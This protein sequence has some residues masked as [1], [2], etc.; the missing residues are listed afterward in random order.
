MG[1]G[2]GYVLRDMRK[3]D[4]GV[5]VT[6]KGNYR[7]KVDHVEGLLKDAGF[8]AT[9]K[10]VNPGEAKSVIEV[11]EF[12]FLPE[13]PSRKAFPLPEPTY[14]HPLRR[15][16]AAVFAGNGLYRSSIQKE[17]ESRFSAGVDYL[18]P[19]KKV[20]RDS[21]GRFAPGRMATPHRPG[22][23]F[24]ATGTRRA[25]LRLEYAHTWLAGNGHKALAGRVAKVLQRVSLHER[26]VHKELL[27][28]SRDCDSEVRVLASRSAQFSNPFP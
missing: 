21:H 10:A 9:A 23:L 3:Y 11:K 8:N 4:M 27:K 14:R 28:F 20:V 7:R 12:S 6:L 15:A 16:L 18:L 17:P 2:T 25:A 5:R 26:V 24:R 19:G 22:G 13:P 1:S